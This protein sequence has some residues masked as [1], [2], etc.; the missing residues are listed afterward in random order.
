MNLKG[1]GRKQSW[2][3]SGF[4]PGNRLESMR[5]T[6]NVCQDSHWLGWD[7][8][9]YLPNTSQ[10]RYTDWTNKLT[11]TG[12]WYYDCSI[13]E[14]YKTHFS[15]LHSYMKGKAIH[16]TDHEGPSGC[17]RSRLPHFQTISSQM[18]VRLSA[19]RAGRP[20]PSGR[21][22]VLISLRAWA[23]PRAIVPMEGLGHLKNAM[24]SGIEPVT[25]RLVA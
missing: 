16:I 9:G 2:F 6:A 3:P 8:N 13:Y 23:D 17:E 25:F 21:F 11:K 24:T 15:K 18:A 7:S 5:K 14:N 10:K 22:L 20:L 12:T 4:H 19:P 1:C